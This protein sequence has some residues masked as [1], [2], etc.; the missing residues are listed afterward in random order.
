MFEDELTGLAEH[1]D[2]EAGAEDME[3][4]AMR[5]EA[6]SEARMEAQ[7][8]EMEEEERRA[9]H[10]AQQAD[11][12]RAVCEDHSYDFWGIPYDECRPTEDDEIP[13]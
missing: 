12:M 1:L 8:Y 2:F 4:W 3:L 10:E 13:F 7:I 5:R 11:P 9:E 6:E